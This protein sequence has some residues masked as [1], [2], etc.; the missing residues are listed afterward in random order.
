MHLQRGGPGDTYAGSKRALGGEGDLQKRRGGPWE[1]RGSK[2][3]AGTRRGTE[4]E[5][6]PF[7]C[8]VAG[9]FLQP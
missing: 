4:H 2:E 9:S 8:P 3:N 6:E 5:C 1:T 7:G